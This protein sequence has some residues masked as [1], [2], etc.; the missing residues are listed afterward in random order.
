MSIN[1][2]DEYI[3][4][5]KELDNFFIKAYNEKKK[6]NIILYF[7]HYH[8]GVDHII[9]V[10]Q[11]FQ[12]LLHII[13]KVMKKKLEIL[14]NYTWDGDKLNFDDLDSSIELFID[15]L[16]FQEVIVVYL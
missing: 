7:T 10:S 4:K 12:V 8:H 15:Q 6:L 1:S 16:L 14:H 5:A 9:I 11:M 13:F 2:S 3:K